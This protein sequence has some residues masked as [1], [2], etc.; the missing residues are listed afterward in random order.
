MMNGIKTQACKKCDIRSLNIAIVMEQSNVI[1]NCKLR[2][3]ILANYFDHKCAT[4]AS[5]QSTLRL[6]YKYI[7]TCIYNMTL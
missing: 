7:Y 2:D 4:L 3:A 6:V 1:C 5:G